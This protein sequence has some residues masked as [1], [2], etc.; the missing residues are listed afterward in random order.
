MTVEYEP[1]DAFPEVSVSQRTALWVMLGLV[2]FYVAV[3]CAFLLPDKPSLLE[4]GA[5]FVFASML[6]VLSYIDL[7]TGFL[8][9]KLTLPLILLGVGY[10]HFVEGDVLLSILGAGLGYGLVATLSFSWKRWRGYEGIGLGDAKLLAA[11]GAWTGILSLPVILLVAS[12]LGLLG[13]LGV[14][15]KARSAG[16]H[17]AIPFGP[18]LAFAGW[19]VWCG[20]EVFIAL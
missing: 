2:I 9:D 4:L 14:S 19:A 10:A 20:F 13:A 1:K 17:V 8:P 6:L 7:R 16:E 18:C 3:F 5:G 11:C 15:Q 12:A